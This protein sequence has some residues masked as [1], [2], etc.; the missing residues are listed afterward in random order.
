MCAVAVV[1]PFLADHDALAFTWWRVDDFCV[2]VASF[3]I[4]RCIIDW[5]IGV[6]FIDLKQEIFIL[7]PILVVARKIVDDGVPGFHPIVFPGFNIFFFIVRF[8]RTFFFCVNANHAM[9]IFRHW[10]S[11]NFRLVLI[12]R[13]GKIWLSILCQRAATWHAIEI[14]RYF[15]RICPIF[16]DLCHIVVD[17]V[18]DAVFDRGV[19]G[20]FVN[21]CFRSVGDFLSALLKGERF[22]RVEFIAI[23]RH[24][25]FI[26]IHSRFYPAIGD[27]AAQRTD[28]WHSC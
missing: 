9:I 26:L 1:A 16:P 17:G 11:R 28:G 22:Y 24:I 8:N 23:G 3:R 10:I 15:V 25:F 19:A 18:S 14:E 5:E 7:A 4:A 12:Q 2:V 13:E 20:V 27:I 6:I 21:C